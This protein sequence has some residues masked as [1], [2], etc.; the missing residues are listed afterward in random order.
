MMKDV[1]VV[2]KKELYRFF[3]DKRLFLT[4][5]LLPGLMIYLMYSLMGSA[6]TN[7]TDEEDVEYIIVSENAPES[8][9]TYLSNLE[10]NYSLKNYSGN[11]EVKKMIY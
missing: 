2:I 6:I 4:V 5:I 10:I 11:L 3:S 1:L 7:L 8:F 9:S